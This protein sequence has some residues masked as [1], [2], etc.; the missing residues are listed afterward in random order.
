MTK[1]ASKSVVA[2][3]TAI[4]I[5]EPYSEYYPLKS[6]AEIRRPIYFFERFMILYTGVPEAHNSLHAW[7]PT[8][9][10]SLPSLHARNTATNA[11]DLK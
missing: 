10:F 3:G 2:S 4:S 1:A 7:L 5:V 9:I 6:P 8:G 11:G